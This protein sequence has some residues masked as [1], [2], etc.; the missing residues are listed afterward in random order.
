MVAGGVGGWLRA[1]TAQTG[2]SLGWGRVR[3]AGSLLS[4]QQLQGQCG[5][6]LG[7]E[8]RSLHYFIIIVTFLMSI[9]SP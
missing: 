9:Q 7:A 1:P 3:L 5:S 8:L 4:D 6:L 2:V